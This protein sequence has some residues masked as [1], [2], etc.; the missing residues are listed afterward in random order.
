MNFKAKYHGTIFRSSRYV[1]RELEAKARLVRNLGKLGVAVIDSGVGVGQVGIVDEE[2]DVRFDFTLVD[3]ISS[4][5]IGYVEVTGDVIDDIYA[6]VLSEKV[7]R[8]RGAKYPVFV[9]YH[10]ERKKMWRVFSVKTVAKC[11]ELVKW[12]E[13]EKPYYKVQL[14]K[15]LLYR[16]WINW[17]RAHVL[18]CIRDSR[19]TCYERFIN[20][21]RVI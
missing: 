9:L 8:A 2:S 12:L 7:E 14:S 17:I 13:D 16:D 20:A 19:H 15:G 18:P 1:S 5:V 10:K 21:W 6:Y 4:K 3:T 11:G